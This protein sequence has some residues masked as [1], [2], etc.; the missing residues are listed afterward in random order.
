MLHS[1]TSTAYEIAEFNYEN[2]INYG[3]INSSAPSDF[4]GLW[5][6]YNL[7]D[8]NGQEINFD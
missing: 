3:F 4:V 6:T 1:F 2:L 7:S 8:Y 5:K